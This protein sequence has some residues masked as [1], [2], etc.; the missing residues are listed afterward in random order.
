MNEDD[1]E[2]ELIKMVMMI[3]QLMNSFFLLDL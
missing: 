3:F 2:R 1:D